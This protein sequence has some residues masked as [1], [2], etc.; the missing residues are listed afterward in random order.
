[1]IEKLSH[2]WGLMQGYLFPNLAKVEELCPKTDRHR[3]LVY[4]LEFVRVENFIGYFEGHVGRPEKD[5]QAIAR[6][7]I[8]KSIYNRAKTK[9]MIDLLHIDPV[10]RRICG[11]ESKKGIPSESTF[12]RAF[13][14]FANSGLAELLHEQFITI[15]HK[16][17]LIGHISR[18]S[19]AIEAREKA[20]VKPLDA[21]KPVSAKRGRP[22]KGEIHP[23]KEKSPT[24]LERQGSMSLLEMLD[25]LP[26]Q[27]D[28]GAKKN[29][30]GFGI[31]WK[32]YKCHIDVADGDI[33][34]SS[35]LTSASVHDSQVALPLSKITHKRLP[36]VCYELMDAAY[37][38]QITRDHIESMDH[39]PLI[40]FNRRGPRDT[41][42]FE[43]FEQQRYKNRSSVER[44]N[45]QLKDNYAGTNFRVRG[46]EKVKAHLSF[47]LL[48]IA[49][50]QS[51]KLLF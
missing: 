24:R 31:R 44:V 18:D 12:S 16:D 25:D 6:V 4:V 46:P 10:L 45:S 40:D 42:Q 1:M 43:P 28:I 51:L 35:L 7:F 49:V 23:A 47:A 41:R 34:V 29:S 13:K 27:C 19:T 14:E 22:K 26:T 17:R 20:F 38:N 21:T 39:V 30:K 3:R 50:E 48:C 36:H 15:Y 37:D 5:R 33:P 2:H 11:F 8:A 32:G 9:D